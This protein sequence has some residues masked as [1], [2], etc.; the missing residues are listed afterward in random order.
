[1]PT[2]DRYS[3]GPRNTHPG[4]DP[5]G[6]P[7]RLRVAAIGRLITQ[8]DM[9]LKTISA[10]AGFSSVQCMTTFLHRHTG[11]TPG[12]LRMVERRLVEQ[13]QPEDDAVAAKGGS[14]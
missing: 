4:A 12:R 3:L 11:S 7:V 2:D 13:S 14:R 8:T 6:P 9:P 10:R 5:F 1:M